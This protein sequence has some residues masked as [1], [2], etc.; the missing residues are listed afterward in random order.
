MAAKKAAA[1]IAQAKENA[2]PSVP[3]SKPGP[4]GF[5][6]VPNTGKVPSSCPVLKAIQDRNGDEPLPQP[7]EAKP[8]PARY[9][10]AETNALE[11][12]A[13][14]QMRRDRMV[15]SLS[16]DVIQKNAQKA[17]AQ[18]KARQQKQPPIKGS[19][20]HR[21][22][23]L[24][25]KPP[26]KPAPGFPPGTAIPKCFAVIDSGRMVYQPALLPDHLLL[27]QTEAAQLAMDSLPRNVTAQQTIAP[28]GHV[29][30]Y[31]TNPASAAA[32]PDA[33]WGPPSVVTWRCKCSI[34]GLEDKADRPLLTC[35]HEDQATRRKCGKRFCYNQFKRCGSRVA[36]NVKPPA[37]SGLKDFPDCVWCKKHDGI[38]LPVEKFKIKVGTRE[39]WYFWDPVEA[40][41][42]AMRVEKAESKM[43]REGWRLNFASQ[44]FK[45]HR[46]CTFNA[47]V[48]VY[49]EESLIWARGHH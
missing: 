27:G 17:I 36:Y 26:A 18:A 16:T 24:M 13:E 32:Q 34:C 23:S 21:R 20:E 4:K 30:I 6:W 43:T 10:V 7:P 19:S 25:T 44:G 38:L 48:T 49:K 45:N 12:A 1:V 28:D 39:D 40:H 47:S 22:A 14:R 33:R 31:L 29:M 42:R 41:T 2:F 46:A 3:K 35:W 37:P 8:P 15:S 9:T 5:E 11:A